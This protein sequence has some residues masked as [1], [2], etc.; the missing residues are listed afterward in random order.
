[1]EHEALAGTIDEMAASATQP[2]FVPC[3]SCG[4]CA[5]A[6]RPVGWNCTI[7]MSRNGSP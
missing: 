4:C 6:R 7:S 1:M 3:R 5:P 2:F